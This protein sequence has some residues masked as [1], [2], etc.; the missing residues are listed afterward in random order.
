LTFTSFQCRPVASPIPRR[1]LPMLLLYFFLVDPPTHPSLDDEE[2][3]GTF[4]SVLISSVYCP[5]SS[6]PSPDLSVVITQTRSLRT[7]PKTPNQHQQKKQP[8]FEPTTTQ[9]TPKP[10]NNP[11][12]PPH[13]H[14]HSP[15]SPPPPILLFLYC[16]F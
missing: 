1:R 12:P 4:F 10:H 2:N 13:Q 3:A 11:P 7:P 9:T 5:L 16:D 8:Q 14:T 6:G 15:Q